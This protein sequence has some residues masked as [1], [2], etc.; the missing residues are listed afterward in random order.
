[1]IIQEK[2]RTKKKRK[3]PKKSDNYDYKDPSSYDSPYYKDLHYPIICDNQQENDSV[4]SNIYVVS[5]KLKKILGGSITIQA[6]SKLYNDELKKYNLY[7]GNEFTIR[8]PVDLRLL[9]NGHPSSLFN[10]VKMNIIKVIEF[11]SNPFIIKVKNITED[12]IEIYLP[13][14]SIIESVASKDPC[15]VAQEWFTKINPNET[16]AVELYCIAK[17]DEIPY[18]NCLLTPFVLDVNES[19]IDNYWNEMKN[20]VLASVIL[21]NCFENKNKEE[22][23]EE[24]KKKKLSKKDNLEKKIK[25]KDE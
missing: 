15:I 5:K 1:M 6:M 7:N 10:L 8:S 9:R 18:G 3:I 22:N 16:E 17:N 2:K 19:R 24:K 23:N 21:S 25:K 20:V 11:C 4:L 13:K 14:G 12:E